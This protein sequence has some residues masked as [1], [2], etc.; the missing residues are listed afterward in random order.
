MA[1]ISVFS[2]GFLLAEMN[3]RVVGYISSE[4]WN[5]SPDIPYSNFSINHS[6]R[7]THKPD[8][9][10]IYISSV[11]VYPDVRGEKIGKKLFLKLL[12]ALQF[13]YDIF[14]SILIVN[15]D[16]ENAYNMYQKEGFVEIGKIDG[17]FPNLN[18]KTGTE[19]NLKTGAEMKSKADANAEP[20]MIEK[21]SGRQKKSGTGIIMRKMF[22]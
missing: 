3:G 4:L 22:K 17:F 2:D 10:E 20:Q 6:I 1:R 14:S 16:W 11:A 7:D 8:G 15:S 19:V 5:Y 12:E 21:S 9:N 13:E 18:L